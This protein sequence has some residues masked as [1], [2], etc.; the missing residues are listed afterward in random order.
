MR[1]LERMKIPEIADGIT[2][3]QELFM[4]QQRINEAQLEAEIAK[5]KEMN[6]DLPIDYDDGIE[7]VPFKETGMSPEQLAKIAKRKQILGHAIFKLAA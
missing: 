5:S 2:D 6:E 4:E 1:Q 7:F 3:N